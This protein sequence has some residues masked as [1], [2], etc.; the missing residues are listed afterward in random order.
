MNNE[1][2]NYNMKWTWNEHYQNVCLF[3]NYC[4]YSLIKEVKFSW[5]R[6]TCPMGTVQFSLRIEVSRELESSE[7]T[8]DGML[9]GNGGGH[10]GSELLFST[11]VLCNSFV[12]NR[13]KF[14]GNRNSMQVLVLKI[15]T[16]YDALIQL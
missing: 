14:F 16:E 7:R 2:K 5:F 4:H 8:N 9:F 6:I 13:S 15:W 10:K 3:E 11:N 12:P 1:V